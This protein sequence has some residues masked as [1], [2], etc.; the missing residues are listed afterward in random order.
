MVTHLDSRKVLPARA[1]VIP[2]NDI[3]KISK[4]SFTRTRGGDPETGKIIEYRN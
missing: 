4:V 1:G 2:L 3:V